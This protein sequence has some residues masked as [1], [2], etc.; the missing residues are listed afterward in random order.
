MQICLSTLPHPSPSCQPGARARGMP[1]GGRRGAPAVGRG[2]TTAKRHHGLPLGLS[3]SWPVSSSPWLGFVA[4]GGDEAAVGE[5]DVVG[6]APPRHFVGA[7]E[8]A[9]APSVEVR[10]CPTH[11]FAPPCSPFRAAL[12]AGPRPPGLAWISSLGRGLLLASG[13]W[14]RVGRGRAERGM[15]SAGVRKER[16]MGASKRVSVFLL[17]MLENSIFWVW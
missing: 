16:G 17:V 4:S 3:S 6:R 1:A 2:R 10:T 5:D 12:L 15:G 14:I 9:S 13:R 8:V 7:G 11:R